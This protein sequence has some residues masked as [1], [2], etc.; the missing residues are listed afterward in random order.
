[1]GSAVHGP[2]WRGQPDLAVLDGFM[3]G[4]SEQGAHDSRSPSWRRR[5]LAQ[6]CRRSLLGRFC[7]RAMALLLAIPEH[8]VSQQ[9]CRS[10]REVG[11]DLTVA[12]WSAHSDSSAS[13]PAS[14]L[15][16][17]TARLRSET[18]CSER[19]HG[20]SSRLDLT[21]PRKTL[22]RRQKHGTTPCWDICSA[23]RRPVNPY[24]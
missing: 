19:A 5:H 17:I 3:P 4:R 21:S 24:R 18:K 23:K 16:L 6:R 11:L 1:M 9:A 2:W 8:E 13:F 12:S 10:E 15:H 22:T 20:L 14:R 7:I